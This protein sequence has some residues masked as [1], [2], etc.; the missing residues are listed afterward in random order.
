MPTYGLASQTW[1]GEQC[2]IRVSNLDGIRIAI[3]PIDFL[4]ACGD[5]TWTYIHQVISELISQED[6]SQSVILDKHGIQSRFAAGAISRG[7]HAQADR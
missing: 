1:R 7:I 5:N 2:V 6:A 3:F 4:R